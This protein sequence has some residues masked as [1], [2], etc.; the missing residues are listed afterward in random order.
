MSKSHRL[1]RGMAALFLSSSVALNAST[2]IA[3]TWRSSIDFAL[4]TSSTVTT[5]DDV[6]KADYDTTEELVAAHRDLGERVSEEGTVLIKNL[7]DTLPLQKTKVTL[8]GM[9]SMYPFLGGVMGSTITSE[10]QVNLVSALQER[11]FE[12]NPTMTDIYTKLG[13]I[14]TGEKQTW[15]GTVPIFGLRPAE[16]A[17][18]YE[19]S[20]PALDTYTAKDEM[21][22]H[23]DENYQESFK[24]YNDAAIVVIS[25]PGSEGNDYYPGEEGIDKEKYGTDSALS[26]TNNEKELLKLAKDNFDKVIVLINAG[27]VMEIEELKNDKDIDAM[28]V[29]GFPGA[30]GMYG[31]A[32]VLNGTANPSGRLAD[33]Y[34]VS[35]ASSPAAQNFGRNELKDLSAIQAPDS[36]MPGLPATSPLGSFGG[37]PAMAANFYLVEAEGIYTGYKYYETRYFDSVLGQGNAKSNVGATSGAKEWD[38]EEEVSYPFGFGLSYTTF[39]QTL[40]KVNVN[41]EERTVTAT[42]TVTNTGEVAGKD[43]AQLYYQAPYS[44]YNKEHNIEKSAIEFLAMEKTKELEPGESQTIT[45]TADAKYM[46][47]WD[48]NAKDGKGGYILDGGDYY[49]AIGTDA[50]NAV[51]N[52][53]AAQGEK[54]TG[55]KELVVTQAVGTEGEVDETTF[56][57]S[58]NGT[59][60]VNQLADADI[61]YYKEGYATYLSRNDWQATF[62]RKY[63]DLTIDGPKKDE[64][65]KNLS[66]EI[67][68]FKK[69]GNVETEGSGGELMLSDL[70]GADINDERWE[71]L[72]A[73]IPLETLVAKITKGGSVSDIIPEIGSPL[74]YQNDGPNG[75]SNILAS[76]GEFAEDKNANFHMATMA[77]L[78]TLGNTFNKELVKEWGQLIGNSGLMSNNLLIWAVGANVHRSAYNG[79]NFEYYSEDDMLSNYMA[80]ATVEGAKEKG[81][82]VGPKHF[83]FNDQET[84]RS[85]VAVYMTEQKARE[86]DLRAFQGAFEEAKALGVMASFSR[87]GATPVNGS[88]AVLENILRK[89]WGFAGILSTDM[90]NNAGYFRPEMLINAGVTMIADFSTDE[91]MTQVNET[92]PYLTIDLIKQDEAFVKKTRENMKYQ[93]HA[94]ANSA[95]QNI[96]TMS[97]TPWWETALNVAI[98][99]T[100][101]LGALSALMYVVSLVKSNKEEA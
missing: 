49:F 89:E 43:V 96:K 72:V 92:W 16:F 65:V 64:W 53:L 29:I 87:I 54:V 48:S 98:Y 4:G 35:N 33:T 41:L 81:V 88:V 32:D 68:Q 37:E 83:A 74:V 1:W 73:Q 6:F 99:T 51:N 28:L 27:N 69:T 34:A 10:E 60:V 45:L 25:R 9:G 26:L 82:I 12:V 2:S 97:V 15:G 66:N 62:P 11:G 8:L 14:Q 78:V 80:A 67:Y 75:F 57:K 39:S 94:F 56:A 101:T 59:E 13:S 70:A 30:Y 90:N 100:G 20:E 44:D 55:V 76:R 5:R 24:E 40:D 3:R 38:Y 84:Q 23:A 42:V 52:I 77:N 36:L 50:H 95:A 7:N 61:N 63:N 31:V 79:R 91:T 21:G 19:P 71:Q 22:G 86:G 58:G 47:T 17:A 93:L 46:T 85:G 18:P